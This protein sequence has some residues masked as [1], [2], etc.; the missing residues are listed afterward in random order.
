MEGYTMPDARQDDRGVG[1]TLVAPASRVWRLRFDG[2]EALIL[3][4]IF[5][6][7]VGAL[8]LTVPRLPTRLV[9]LLSV[10][11]GLVGVAGLRLVRDSRAPAVGEGGS[12][13]VGARSLASLV[14]LGVGWFV[15]VVGLLGLGVVVAFLSDVKDA[16]RAAV[17]I[18]MVP[19]A[20][21]AGLVAG[22]LRVGRQPAQK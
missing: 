9:A 6:V 4:L 14:L 1:P 3:A 12:E 8:Q 19:L 21:G 20:I 7:V 17:L 16:S 13:L 18:P 15:V 11:G 10:G 5:A 22:G 2:V